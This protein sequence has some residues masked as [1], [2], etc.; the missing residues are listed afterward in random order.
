VASEGPIDV[1]ADADGDRI[2]VE[3]MGPNVY[4]TAYSHGFAACV[5]LDAERRDRFIKAWDE[6]ERRAEA[7]VPGGE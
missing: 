1:I 4:L 7:V 2:A 3:V 5:R 6:A